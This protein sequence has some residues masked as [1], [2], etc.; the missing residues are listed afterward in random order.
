MEDK[1]LIEEVEA[2][3][4]TEE[5]SVHKLMD[6]NKEEKEVK[7]FAKLK[8]KVSRG[9]RNLLNKISNFLN[10]NKVGQ[11]IKKIFKYIGLFFYYLGYP[12]VAGT[13][14]AE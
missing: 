1:N 8:E 14:S 2:V 11:V 12:F 7:G 5:E 13:L 4:S 10:N 9:F 3:E 6:I